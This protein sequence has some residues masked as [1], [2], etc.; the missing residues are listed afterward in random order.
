MT[1][2]VLAALL[3]ACAGERQVDARDRAPA[4]RL[5]LRRSEVSALRV[6]NIVLEDSVPAKPG[7]ADGDALPYTRNDL[8][9]T[10][11][12]EVDDDAFVLLV[13]RP[14]LALQV[15][16]ERAGIT[17]GWGGVSRYRSLWQSRAPRP[18]PAGQT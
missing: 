11:T 8:G 16:L 18:H 1:A 14:V 5:R 9:R 15:L 7:K 3:K 2:D 6:E 10:K 4:A 17:V 12:T 13:G